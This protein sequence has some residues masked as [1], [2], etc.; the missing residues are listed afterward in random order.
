MI[1]N[2]LLQAMMESL[3]FEM[4]RHSNNHATPHLLVAVP[5][6]ARELLK[7]YRSTYTAHYSYD[8]T[9]AMHSH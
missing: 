8:R 3:L 5:S 7:N 9:T 2:N 1:A 4:L 6:T